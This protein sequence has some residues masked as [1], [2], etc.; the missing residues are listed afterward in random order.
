[1]C[2]SYMFA[3]HQ[4]TTMGQ[5]QGNC[6]TNPCENKSMNNFGQDVSNHYKGRMNE[7]TQLIEYILMIE[8]FFPG[9]RMAQTTEP[10]HA[11]SS[12]TTCKVFL[13]AGIACASSSRNWKINVGGEHKSQSQSQPGRSG[14]AIKILTAS[15]RWDICID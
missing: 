6:S 3:S 2:L 12:L 7:G 4:Q 10:L 13:T 9:Q 11:T 15:G 5:W 1:M 8:I 14:K